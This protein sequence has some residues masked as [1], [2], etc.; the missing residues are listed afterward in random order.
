MTNP[1]IVLDTNSLLQILGAR[2]KYHFLFGKFLTNEFTLCVSTE[3]LFEYEEILRMK[4]SPAAA[5]LFLK[6]IAR[7]RNVL[8]KD[9]YFRL[10]LVEQDADDNKFVDCAFVC[11]ADYIVTDDGHFQDVSDSSFPTFRVMGL[12]EFSRQMLQTL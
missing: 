12:D 6:V 11:Q 5:E 8:R 4:A 2:S 3:I 7:S 10:H 1:R 9:P